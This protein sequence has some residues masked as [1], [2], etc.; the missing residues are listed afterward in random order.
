MTTK[1]GTVSRM[2]T[3]RDMR[4][5]KPW[6][7]SSVLQREKGKVSF[8]SGHDGTRLPE[9]FKNKLYVPVGK[10]MQRELGMLAHAWNSST[11]G[12]ERQEGQ[13]FKV[14]LGYNTKFEARMDYVETQS[15]TG[16]ARKRYIL[17]ASWRGLCGDSL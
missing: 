6:V 17:K 2:Q 1:P 3:V 10:L 8:R 5:E 13:E 16:T 9:L 4:E 15:Q 14:S 11:W 7:Q 12:G